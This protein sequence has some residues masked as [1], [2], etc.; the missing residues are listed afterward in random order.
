MSNNTNPKISVSLQKF[1]NIL[2]ISP[3]GMSFSK[4]C[5]MGFAS[6]LSFLG[7]DSFRLNIFI[8]RMT[9]YPEH[10]TLNLRKTSF[11]INI[12]ENI[13]YG[14]KLLKCYILTILHIILQKL[15]RYSKFS[16]LSVQEIKKIS[17]ASS[18]IYRTCF[19]LF[20]DFIAFLLV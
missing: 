12:S 14:L 20:S 2:L 10:Y 11:M 9:N 15:Y 8:V 19:P 1:K 7:E 17:K 13:N 16:N 5:F 18:L 6:Q 3:F 4:Y